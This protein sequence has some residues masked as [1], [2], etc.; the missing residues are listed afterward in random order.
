MTALASLRSVCEEWTI[1]S[2]PQHIAAFRCSVA[3]TVSPCSGG[4]VAVGKAVEDGPHVFLG[5]LEPSIGTEGW[6]EAATCSANSLLS[7]SVVLN[8]MWH[9]RRIRFEEILCCS[10]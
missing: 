10:V 5:Y 4:F 9:C 6:W 3:F 7:S 2:R 8:G 1:E